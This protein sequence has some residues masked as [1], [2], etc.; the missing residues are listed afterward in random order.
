MER[1]E[2]VG[3]DMVVSLNNQV[4]HPVVGLTE[5]RVEVLHDGV[6]QAEEEEGHVGH[7]QGHQ[8]VVE[9][10]LERFL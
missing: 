2:E 5:R 3:E 4:H 8:Q 7:C 10:A 1:V 6:S 9:I